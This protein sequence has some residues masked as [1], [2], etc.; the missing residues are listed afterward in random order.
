MTQRGRS[1]AP[2]R[3]PPT[4]APVPLNGPDLNPSPDAPRRGPGERVRRLLALGIL[5]ALAVALHAW[6][7]AYTSEFGGFE[8][9]PAHLV[10]ALMLRDWL[11]SLDFAD[12]RGF[13]ETYYLHYPKVA[14]GQWPPVFHGAL[15][16]WML[17]FGTSQVAVA[18]FLSLIAALVAFTVQQVLRR[19][20]GFAASVAGGALYL[21]VPVAF[22]CSQSV[23][24]ETTIALL[25]LWAVLSF[26]NFM[27]TGRWGWMAA[28]GVLGA[29]T[30]LTKGSGLALAPL[31][32]VALLAG[33][34]LGLMA[35]PALWM[36]GLF[37]AGVTAPWYLSTL[38]FNQGTWAGGTSPSM[39][40]ARHAASA[41][42]G[43]LPDLTGLLGCALLPLG[44]L[45]GWRSGELHGRW[46]ALASWLPCVVAIHLLVPSSVEQ[47]HLSVLAPSWVV[48][49][50]LGAGVA[51]RHVLGRRSPVLARHGALLGVG[52]VM[53]GVVGLGDRLHAKSWSGWAAAGEAYALEGAERPTRVLAA[54][55]PV[56]E[57]LLVAGVA[58]AQ[59]DRPASLVMRASK[60]LGNAA[61]NGRDY[62]VRFADAAAV[63]QF[64]VSMGVGAV[65]L[66][67]SVRGSRHWYTH[68][69]QL[70]ELVAGA[71]WSEVSGEPV[72]RDGAPSEGRIRVFLAP[73]WATL[74]A[75]RLELGDVLR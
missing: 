53:A 29:L 37:V 63:G 6:G 50:A 16:L 52:V 17:A 5:A 12:P 43:W 58:F 66:D 70:E 35:R 33:R 21:L 47:R 41:F 30:V 55:D 25:S 40:Y 11:A 22:Q 18:S 73:G 4:P 46:V 32:L 28:F 42:G 60:V 34:R 57:G 72:V 67:E 36:A 38:E 69:D 14:I 27:D 54:S 39:G 8:D 9:E 71:G 75:P 61:W 20:L 59:E 3:L 15:A 64:L 44:V 68:M 1:A 7:G 48:F 23:M 56:G 13:V 19:P 49:T 62:E 2:R 31:P 65:I 26:G 45:W 74:D 10:T 51:G 24:T